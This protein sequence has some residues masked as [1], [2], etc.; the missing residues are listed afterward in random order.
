MPPMPEGEITQRVGEE[1]CKRICNTY[2]EVFNNEKGNFLGANATMI[3]KPGGLE[4]IK[5]SGFRPAAKVPYGLEAQFEEH[6]DKLYEDLVIVDG[7][8]LI[9][10]CVPNST[11][12]R[13]G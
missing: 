2:P 7:K 4:K 1:F 9:H 6:L 3:L 10:N 12:H 5:Q 13:N 8:D 11:C